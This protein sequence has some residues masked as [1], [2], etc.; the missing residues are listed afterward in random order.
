[1]NSAEIDSPWCGVTNLCLAR[2]STNSKGFA[3]RDIMDI[4]NYDWVVL[5]SV[6]IGS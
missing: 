4:W 6:A 5:V 2:Q 3:R 1:M